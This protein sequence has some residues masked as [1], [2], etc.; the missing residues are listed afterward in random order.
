MIIDGTAVAAEI[1]KKIK[2]QV[3]KIK[4][5]KPCLAVILVGEHPPSKIYVNRKTKACEEVG[6]KSI[7]R[8]FPATITE[9][10]LLLEIEHYNLNQMLTE[11]WS[12]SPYLNTST[13]HA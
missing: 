4:G 13:L 6:I 8:Q 10:E 2:S 3:D 12:N 5:R 1:Q 11:S 7:K 9:N